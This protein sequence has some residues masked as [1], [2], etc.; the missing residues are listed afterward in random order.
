MLSAEG[1][2]VER[3]WA[4]SDGVFAIAMTLLVLDLSVPPRLGDAAFRAA[5]REVMPNLAAYA[6]SFVVIAQFWRD[7]RRILGLV[8]EVDTPVVSLA[9]FGLGL[10]ALLPFP[11]AVLAEYNDEPEAVALYSGSVA[12]LNLVHLALMITVYRR[13]GKEGERDVRAR[14]LDVA[15]LAVT[16]F[17]FGLAVPLA[18]VSPLGAKWF[19]IVL[20]P[21][22]VTIG[23]KA[24]RTA[25]HL[26]TEQPPE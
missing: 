26:S 18:F 7:H 15:D 21:A 17:V 8:S 23:R 10:T 6:L 16:V 1:G 13:L 5:L 2:G 12:A 3:L 19:W 4:L 24:R 20:V 25:R 11:T 9:L 22:K 14:R